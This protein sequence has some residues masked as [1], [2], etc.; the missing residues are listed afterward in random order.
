MVIPISMFIVGALLGVPRG[1]LY[2]IRPTPS[3]KEYLLGTSIALGTPI[4]FGI[5]GVLI[6]VAIVRLL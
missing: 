5:L 4:T 3:W 1:Y 2:I 6:K